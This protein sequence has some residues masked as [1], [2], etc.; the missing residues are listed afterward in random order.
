[1]F[2]SEFPELE[3]LLFCA[4]DVV[5]LPPEVIFGNCLIEAGVLALTTCSF[6]K[7]LKAF[8]LPIFLFFKIIFVLFPGPRFVFLEWC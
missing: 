6:P 5:L 8:G 3:V 7:A 1:M 4:E 2:D